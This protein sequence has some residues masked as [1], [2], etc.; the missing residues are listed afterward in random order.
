MSEILLTGI[1]WAILYGDKRLIFGADPRRGSG[2]YKVIGIWI[3]SHIRLSRPFQRCI[4]PDATPPE[5]VTHL[6]YLLLQYAICDHEHP[7]QQ[8]APA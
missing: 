4:D 8:Q 6:R 1:T 7:R 2:E 5:G 3:G